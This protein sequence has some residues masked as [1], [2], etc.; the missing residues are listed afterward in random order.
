M[1]VLNKILSDKDWRNELDNEL[2]RKLEKLLKRIKSEEEAYKISNHEAVAQLWVGIAEVF[3]KVER[4]DQRMR[5]IEKMLEEETNKD[6]MDDT[7]LR[8]SLEKY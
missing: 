1:E 8:K 2:K 6:G 7:E 3:S 4:L 5:R